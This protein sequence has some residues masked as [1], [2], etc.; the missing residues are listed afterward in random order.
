MVGVGTV[1]RVLNSGAHVS[2]ATTERVE[3]AIRRLG[4]RPNAQARRLLRPHSEIVCFLLSNRDFPHTFHARILQGVENYARSIRQHVIFAA[5]HYDAGTSPE[6]IPLPPILQER[7]MVDGL[8]L[9]GTVYANFLH[10]IQQME[11][12]FVAFGNNVMKYEGQRNFDQVSY[13]AFPGE[14]E[15]TLY[16]IGQGHRLIAFGGDV[17]YPWMR[18][19]NE[20]YLAAM[21]ER[22][23]NPI[24]FTAPKPALSNLEYGDWLASRALARKPRPTAMIAGND[25]VAFGFWRSLRRRG[26]RIPE[27]MSLVGFDDREE[28]TLMDPPLT[29]VRVRK[30]EVGQACMKM[31]LERLHHPSMAYS[32]RLLATELVVRETVKGLSR[33]SATGSAEKERRLPARRKTTANVELPAEG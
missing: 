7:G 33:S 1:S 22:N 8:I 31:L 26:L 14:R 2:R 12:P 30:E 20:A 4:F 11:I 24:A 6:R 18:V 16:T 15:A 10:R 28:A 29:T 25:E 19:R 21:R 13:D 5:V 17:S 32:E 3:A 9:A 23:L 27:D